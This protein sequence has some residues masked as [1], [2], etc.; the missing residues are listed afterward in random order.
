[1][2]LGETIGCTCLAAGAL[3]ILYGLACQLHRWW[4]KRRWQRDIQRA[5]KNLEQAD[6][7]RSRAAWLEAWYLQ[8]QELASLPEREPRKPLI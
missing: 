2:T 3:L 4:D 5:E 7:L 8:A 1:M 6:R